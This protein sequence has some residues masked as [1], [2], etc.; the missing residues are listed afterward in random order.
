MVSGNGK[1]PRCR[2]NTEA[3]NHLVS[4]ARSSFREARGARRRSPRPVSMLWRTGPAGPAPPVPPVLSGRDQASA[5][6]LIAIS[7]PLT[8]A[9][10][11]EITMRIWRLH[12]YFF[13]KFCRQQRGNR[14]T[15]RLLLSRAV[16]PLGQIIAELNR[17]PGALCERKR[18]R[19]LPFE[20]GWPGGFNCP[21]CGD[22]RGWLRRAEAL[23]THFACN[24]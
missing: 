9:D 22:G 13:V 15:A 11:Q 1:N 17:V 18:M 5:T 21:G 12:D 14:R 8:G 20:R 19:G 7:H 6:P 23:P 4:T 24:L 16:Y 2:R 10:A 3:K